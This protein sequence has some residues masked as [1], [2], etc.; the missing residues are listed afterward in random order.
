MIT[1]CSLHWKGY[2]RKKKS[3]QLSQNGSVHTICPVILFLLI[4]VLDK[5]QLTDFCYVIIMFT[6]Y[7]HAD[8]S[9]F[10]FN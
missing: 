2:C 6:P 3:S 7:S 5:V 10:N 8:G 4:I 1:Y 9:I